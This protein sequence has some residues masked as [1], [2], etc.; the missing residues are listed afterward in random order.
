M[1]RSR[2]FDLQVSWFETGMFSDTSEHLWSNF[3]FVVKGKD[4]IRPT[5][6]LENFVRAGF[7]LDAPPDPKKGSENSPGLG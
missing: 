6:A 1:S 2:H 4:Y 3:V 7:A 5:Q